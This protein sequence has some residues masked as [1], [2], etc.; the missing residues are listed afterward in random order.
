MSN[1]RWI[2]YDCENRPI[3]VVNADGASEEYT[4]DYSGQRVKKRVIANGSEA[5]SV[6]IGTV[7]KKTA[8]DLNN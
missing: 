4:Y 6:Y 8:R 2:K 5:I 7:Y 1:N 3:K